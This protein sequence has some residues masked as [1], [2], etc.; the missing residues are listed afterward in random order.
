MTTSVFGQY[1]YIGQLVGTLGML[2]REIHYI[3]HAKRDEPPKNWQILLL[4]RVINFFTSW[5]INVI[6]LI[7]YNVLAQYFV[8]DIFF[9]LICYMTCYT[10]CKFVKA[11]GRSRNFAIS[12]IGLFVTMDQG[13]QSLTVVI[14]SSSILEF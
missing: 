14:N 6:Y 9:Y 5:K 13:F 11:I 3:P 8:E 10:F 4:R 2:Q 12:K 1:W 7:F